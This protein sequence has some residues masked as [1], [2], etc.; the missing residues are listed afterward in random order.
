M[1]KFGALE[2]KSPRESWERSTTVPGSNLLLFQAHL[3]PNTN[4]SSRHVYAAVTAGHLPQR[5]D[6]AP[7]LWEAQPREALQQR[8]VAHQRVPFTYDEDDVHVDGG[9]HAARKRQHVWFDLALLGGGV[10]ALDETGRL[11]E[12]VHVVLLASEQVN[13]SS[14]VDA[15]GPRH[16]C[17]Q[18]ARLCPHVVLHCVVNDGVRQ[19]VLQRLPA[20]GVDGVFRG[21]RHHGVVEAVSRQRCTALPV[22]GILQLLHPQ[23][24]GAVV[25]VVDQQLEDGGTHVLQLDEAVVGLFEH[26]PVQVKL[27]FIHSDG[28]I[29]KQAVLQAQVHD[30]LHHAAGMRAVSEEPPTLTPPSSPDSIFA[31][32][33]RGMNAQLRLWLPIILWLWLGQELQDVAAGSGPNA[34]LSDANLMFEILLSGV[35]LNKDNNVFLLD[36]ELASMRKGREF[37]SQ[38]NDGIPRT[39]ISTELMIKTQEARLK[40]PL[41]RDQF[42]NQ[43]LSMVYSALQIG[44]QRNKEEREAWGEV[45]IQLANITTYDLRGGS[46]VKHLKYQLPTVGV[47]DVN[48]PLISSADAVIGVSAGHNQVPELHCVINRGRRQQPVASGVKLRMLSSPNIVVI[49][50]AV[51]CSGQQGGSVAL[52]AMQV[53]FQGHSSSGLLQN[54]KKALQNEETHSI[55]YQN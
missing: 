43:V 13:G 8:V 19:R 31:A 9:V 12:K 20:Q 26:Q 18:L 52:K 4:P 46:G 14:Q 51:L 32:C 1:E 54:C 34:D 17:V 33:H 40:T 37:L 30:A 11:C 35:E 48:G 53:Y 50:T 44:V 2:N 47:K 55:S 49:M 38:I 29:C 7:H 23:L 27:P 22:H 41:T 24:D 15:S 28:D 3:N 21:H 16:G 36:E 25:D 10:E 39:L 5:R 42:E 45:L 6:A